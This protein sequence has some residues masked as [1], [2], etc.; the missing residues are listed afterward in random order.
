MIDWRP[1]Q[2]LIAATFTPMQEDGALNL[3]AVPAIAD[4]VIGQGVDGL[5]VC[6]STGEGTS[7]T[8]NERR[9]VSEAYIAAAAGRVPVIVHVGHNSVQEASAL[10]AH[11]AQAG[12]NAIAATPPAYFRPT[13]VEILI[14]CLQPVARAASD[15]PFYYY[16]IP[17][18]TGV[19]LPMIDFLAAARESL[20]TLAGIKFSNTQLNDLLSC[21]QF[22]G[23][24]YNILFGADEMLLA[25]LAMGAAGAVGSTYN[26]L[27]PTYRGVIDAFE[28][29]QI[30]EA[31]HCQARATEI[32]HAILSH[33]GHNA[34]KAAMCVLGEDCGPPRLPIAALTLDQLKSLETRLGVF[35]E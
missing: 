31:Q 33:G 2:G 27:A 1:L 24:R 18:L 7:L 10:A 16:H 11:A 14:E 5:F 8:G 17:A 19:H 13:S 25:G 32:V 4:F 15:L 35:V 9:A 12:A 30:S 20:P 6:G 23:G 21:V 22:E 29:G 28:A 3:N 34:L 26:F